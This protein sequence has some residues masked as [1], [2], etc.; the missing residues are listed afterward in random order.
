MQAR[1]APQRQAE[2]HALADEGVDTARVLGLEDLAAGE[3]LFVA[4][5]V[6][7]GSIARGP[8]RLHRAWR[9][10]SIVISDG[11]VRRVLETSFDRDPNRKD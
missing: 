2:A 4:T 10:D 7:N 11:S 1:L 6:T 9:T 3:S 8:A 5:G